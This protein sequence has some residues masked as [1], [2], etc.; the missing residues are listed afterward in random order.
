MHRAF[1]RVV[2]V[3][4]AV[5][6]SR[7]AAGSEPAPAASPPEPP[8]PASPPPARLPTWDEVRSG[9]PEGAT[10]PPSPL[11]IVTKE[12]LGCYKSWR[13][14]MLAAPPDL[15][16]AGGQV[17]DTPAEVGSAT[18]VQCPPGQPQALL[19]AWAKRPAGPTPK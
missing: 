15:R 3:A 14:G 19:E 9:H 10:N 11:L 6:A 17:V 4:L 18:A 2:G 1:V 13:S 16:A 8:S 5:S 12:P 7:P